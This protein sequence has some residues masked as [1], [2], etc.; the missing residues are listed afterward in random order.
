M[1]INRLPIYAALSVAMMLPSLNAQGN[2]RYFVVSNNNVPHSGQNGASVLDL[3][4]STLFL[5]NILPVTG[6]G[7]SYEEFGV[8]Q[9]AITVVGTS[10]C[11]L[12]SE[13]GSSAI[14]TFL[15]PASGSP[16]QVGTYTDFTGSGTYAGVALAVRGTLLIAGYTT[17][18]NL[19][20]WTV[21][22]DC[23]LT[24]ESAASNTTINGEIDGL[25]ITPN[26][27]TLVVTHASNSVN[28]FA[29]S[30]STLTLKGTY[31]TG[32]G[33]AGVDFTADSKYVLIGDYTSVDT[34]LDIF[35]IHPDSTLGADDYYEF[36]QGGRDSNNVWISP[37][38]TVVYVSNSDSYQVTTLALTPTAPAGQRL[39]FVCVSA[40]LTNP[41]FVFTG[42]IATAEPTG[43]GGYLYV[44]ESGG[45]HNGVAL[46]SIPGNGCPVEVSESPTAIPGNGW[47][48]TL[49]AYPPRRF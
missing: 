42:G 19:A 17:T 5:R 3:N 39:S 23:S 6:S 27:H 48:N 13:G 38:S 46:M 1:T 20:V 14:T 40:P 7:V 26:R 32:G 30:G 11:A 9:Q 10:V 28:A 24:L 41:G 49:A 29:I 44:A 47:S 36:T 34:Q 18:N 21:N 15:F 43:K 2:S 8:E 33:T 25:G 12:V 4:G 35:P 37:D 22:S 16:T 31:E 45:T